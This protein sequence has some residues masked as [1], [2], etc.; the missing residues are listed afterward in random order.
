MEASLTLRA[1]AQLMTRAAGALQLLLPAEA[2]VV[3]CAFRCAESRGP[4]H[5]LEPVL[6]KR[7]E[8]QTAIRNIH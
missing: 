3:T 2:L 5:G 6:M 7:N 1:I 8:L 4:K